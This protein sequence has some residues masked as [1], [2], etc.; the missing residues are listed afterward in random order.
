MPFTAPIEKTAQLFRHIFEEASLGLAIE[1]LEGRLLLANLALCSILGFTEE[2]L[3]AMSCSN[4][5]N[6]EDSQGDWAL[7]QKVRAGLIDHYSIE[8]RYTRKDGACVWG[9]LNV[10]VVKSGDGGIPLVVAFVEDVTKRKLAEEA[11]SGV[12]RKLIE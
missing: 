4:F 3:C 6:P 12:S 5:T 9:H 2:E 11:L 8:K 10:S 7:F 1:E